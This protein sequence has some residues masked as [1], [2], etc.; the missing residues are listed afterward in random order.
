M[1]GPIV[2]AL[3]CGSTWEAPGIVLK[4]SCRTRL[5][6]RRHTAVLNSSLSRHCVLT[7]LQLH[8]LP[9]DKRWTSHLSNRLLHRLD[10]TS[11]HILL[12][13]IWGK[14]ATEFLPWVQRWCIIFHVR[15]WGSSVACWTLI[16]LL[17]LSHY[18]VA[19]VK[20]DLGLT[21]FYGHLGWYVRLAHLWR[22]ILWKRQAFVRLLPDGSRNFARMM[23]HCLLRL[24]LCSLLDMFVVD[25]WE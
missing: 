1:K 2:N 17:R 18:H 4:V 20:S 25:R 19:R 22:H 13:P 3:I 21:N 14:V 11:R 5:I 24:G 16:Y 15:V 8:S 12:I 6:A 23:L 10:F 7:R 9:I